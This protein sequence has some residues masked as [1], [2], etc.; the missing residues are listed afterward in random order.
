V[1]SGDRGS[2]GGAVRLSARLGNLVSLLFRATS[3]R[4]K[5]GQ[6]EKQPVPVIRETFIGGIAVMGVLQWAK[7][8]H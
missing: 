6:P 5:Y 8:L 7:V 2:S 1:K 4:V 3:S